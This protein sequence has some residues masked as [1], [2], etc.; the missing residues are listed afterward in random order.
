MVYKEKSMW[1]EH[2]DG[3]LSTSSGYAPAGREML[4][5]PLNIL[6]TKKIENKGD[7]HNIKV[8]T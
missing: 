1:S 3:F 5:W 4:S 8:A 6:L 2:W 7:L